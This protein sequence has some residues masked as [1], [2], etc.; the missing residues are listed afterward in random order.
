MQFT[1]KIYTKSVISEISNLVFYIEKNPK[2]LFT[3][4][5]KKTPIPINSCETCNKVSSRT[6]ANI[7]TYFHNKTGWFG[8]TFILLQYHS[9]FI[10]I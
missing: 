4:L 6:S 1:L 9:N 3:S 5:S 8:K 7:L 2:K 10:L